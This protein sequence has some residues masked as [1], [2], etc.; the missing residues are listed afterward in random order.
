MSSIRSTSSPLDVWTL[1][2]NKNA[3]SWFTKYYFHP[4]DYMRHL[5]LKYFIGGGMFL[6]K[7]TLIS[8][9]CFLYLCSATFHEVFHCME[10][11]RVVAEKELSITE[12]I[13]SFP[14]LECNK[15]VDLCSFC[16]NPP[17]Q[18]ES[19]DFPVLDFGP[20]MINRIS[21]HFFGPPKYFYI[22]P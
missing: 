17:A 12:T 16:S 22:P 1:A 13:D 7:N 8:I 4:I 19:S 6:Y 10:V 3:V 21:F 14:H 5:N 2:P 20:L 9:T 15:K 11:Y 18:Y